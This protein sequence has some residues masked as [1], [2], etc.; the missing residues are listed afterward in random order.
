[1]PECE[2]GSGG[3]AGGGGG[4]GGGEGGAVPAPA[5]GLHRP[6]GHDLRAPLAAPAGPA[7]PGQ[8]HTLLTCGT[9]D[10]TATTAARWSC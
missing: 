3:G 10:S 5:A 6:A 8:P 1:M 2:A 7:L 9:H 4:D